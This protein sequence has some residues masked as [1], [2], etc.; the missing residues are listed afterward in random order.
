MCTIC[1]IYWF[2][3]YDKKKINV[4]IMIIDKNTHNLYYLIYLINQFVLFFVYLIYNMYQTE[5]LYLISY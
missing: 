1:I 4:N 3:L 2:V 5:K